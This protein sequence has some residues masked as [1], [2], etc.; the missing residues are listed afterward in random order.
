MIPQLHGTLPVRQ[1][2]THTGQLARQLVRQGAPADLRQPDVFGALFAAAPI[3]PDIHFEFCSE[4]PELEM[5]ALT[6]QRREINSIGS[7]AFLHQLHHHTPGAAAWL[8]T[9]LDVLFHDTVPFSTPAWSRR[10]INRMFGMNRSTPETRRATYNRRHNTNYRAR[11]TERL[12]HREGHWTT[13]S[14]EQGYGRWMLPERACADAPGRA[15]LQTI[16]PRLLTLLERAAALPVSSAVTPEIEVV[17]FLLEMP[18]DIGEHETF[19]AEVHDHM[20]EYWRNGAES[21]TVLLRNAVEIRCT[22]Q[23]L[24]RQFE[25]AHEI[26]FLMQA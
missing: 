26:A 1:L 11:L 14:I 20:T 16:C 12:I 18:Q 17:A 3:L 24:I 23:R 5:P 9:Q 22:Y 13:Y 4:M 21:F 25:L 6:A 2:T 10:M 8:L 19:A 15:A 7:G